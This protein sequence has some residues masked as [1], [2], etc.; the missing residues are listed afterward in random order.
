M[1]MGTSQ[2][3][4][5]LMQVLYRLDITEDEIHNAMTNDRVIHREKIDQR[6]LDIVLGPYASKG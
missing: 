6:S 3:K 5:F 1:P 2:S 4:E